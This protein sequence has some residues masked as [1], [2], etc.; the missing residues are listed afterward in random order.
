MFTNLAMAD[1]PADEKPVQYWGKLFSWTDNKAQHPTEGIMFELL[2]EVT[3]Q[4][5][6]YQ[7]HYIAMSLSRGFTDMTH[8]DDLCMVGMMRNPE[9]DRVGYFV[10]LWPVLP[11]Q[12]VIRRDDQ[13]FITR[14]QK[15]VS[16]AAVLERNDLR[17]AVLEGRYFGPKLDALLQTAKSAGSVQS[18]Q[19]SANANNLLSMLDVGR[20]DFSLDFLETFQT[21]SESRPELRKRL[22][23]VP[24]EEVQTPGIGGI[25]CSRTPRGKQL[26]ERIDALAQNPRLQ[27]RFQKIIDRYLPATPRKP[28]AQWTGNYY[29]QRSQQ[30]I[31]NLHE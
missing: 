15:R 18:L 10:G 29:Q 31:T 11:P 22:M 23:L 28:Y 6:E 26:I 16:L 25:Y 19:T 21:S 12:L 4:L 14:E 8:R 13:Q 1:K 30:S 2:H 27:A 17:G 7:H 5:P 3:R 9:R 20:I 24:L